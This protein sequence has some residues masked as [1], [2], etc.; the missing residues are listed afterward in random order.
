VDFITF[1]GGKLFFTIIMILVPFYLYGWDGLWKYILPVELVSRGEFLASTF[2]VSHNT[3]EIHYNCDGEDWHN[4]EKK[5]GGRRREGGGRRRK[6]E[7]AGGRRE[8]HTFQVG[9]EFLASTFVVSH[10]TEEI[11]YNCDGG[12][13]AEMQIKASANWS[14]HSTIWWLVSVCPPS[15]SLPPPPSYRSFLPSVFPLLLP[16]PLFLSP[17]PLPPPP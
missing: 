1:Y 8:T 14:P 16:L 2:V 9:G 4:E 10:N 3:E 13:W 11:H 15:P 6:E 7:E 12:D 17:P 5:G